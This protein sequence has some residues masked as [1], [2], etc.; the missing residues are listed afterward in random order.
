MKVAIFKNHSIEN[1]E[2]HK[3]SLLNHQ[4]YAD[5]HGYDLVTWNRPYS[6]AMRC[7]LSWVDRLLDPYEI[8]VTVG[9]DV[10]FTRMETPIESFLQPGNGVVISEEDVG[11][12]KVNADLIIWTDWIEGR[13]IVDLLKQSA[14]K[15][16]SHP[17]GVQQGFNLLRDAKVRGGKGLEGVRFA[18][19][20]E[21]QSSAVRGFPKSMWQ[22]G[23]FALHFLGMSNEDK[24][25]KVQ[26]F[27]KTGE[28]L[29]R[30]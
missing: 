22:P 30:D 21:L 29:W 12:S 13:H 9:S 3:A 18:P 14:G 24:L 5:R 16:L 11:G 25:T 26:H 27:L 19:C 1:N 7:G 17:W 28:V 8:V 23:D 2:L 15:W 10:L 20:R 4:E 6:E